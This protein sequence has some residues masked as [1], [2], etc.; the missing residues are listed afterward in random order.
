[1]R[2]GAV[3][4]VEQGLEFVFGDQLAATAGRGGRRSGCCRHRRGRQRD[5]GRAGIA[6]HVELGDQLGRGILRLGAGADGVDHLLQVIQRLLRGVEMAR[7]HVHLPRA[8]RAERILGGVAQMHHRLD[9]EEAGAALERVEAAEHR[10][11]LV[12]VLGGVFQLDQLL[13]EPVDDFLCFDEEVGGDFRGHAA[14]ARAPAGRRGGMERR[15]GSEAQ[16]GEQF[17]GIVLGKRI[18]VQSSNGRA[19]QI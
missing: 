7:A 19:G 18:V 3:Q 8:D 14:H 1:M 2:R 4:L 17:V 15:A 11:E 6:G 12:G 13:A 10:V 9:A 5:G 16:A